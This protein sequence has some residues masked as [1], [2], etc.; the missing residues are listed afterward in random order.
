[1]ACASRILR[2]AVAIC[3]GL[4]LLPGP[5]QAES[6]DY[7]STAAGPC[8]AT[9]TQG[10]C[11]DYYQAFADTSYQY[12]RS[13]NYPGPYADN[14]VCR[15]VLSACRC[16]NPLRPEA[17][18]RVEFEVLDF[19]IQDSPSC[20]QDFVEVKDGKRLWAHSFGQYCGNSCV[21][22]NSNNLTQSTGLHL[23]VTFQTD[24]FNARQP[25]KYRGFQARYRCV[26][27]GKLLR[28]PVLELV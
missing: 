22:G 8:D 26:E 17:K 19:E 12:I 1:M 23:L 27:L 15:W 3:C 6:C 18:F 7:V 14:Q 13:P 5:A 11:A 2:A 25:Q 21:K 4:L 16:S 28:S 24:V 9:A 10:S 20:T